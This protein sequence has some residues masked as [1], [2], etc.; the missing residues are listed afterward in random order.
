M[1]KLH[2]QTRSGT[3]LH[4][5]Y[6]CMDTSTEDVTDGIKAVLLE[7]K[8]EKPCAS[9]FSEFTAYLLP[10]KLQ[11]SVTRAHIRGR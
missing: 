11:N 10:L 6:K 5:V 3:S 9:N 4:N 2:M 8:M 1:A 7:K